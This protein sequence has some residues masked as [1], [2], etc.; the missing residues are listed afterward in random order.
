MINDLYNRIITNLSSRGHI[1][2]VLDTSMYIPPR[3]RFLMSDLNFMK[4]LTLGTSSESN[5]RYIW[6]YSDGPALAESVCVSIQKVCARGH[7]H[8][9]SDPVQA[10]VSTWNIG[11]YLGH[12]S[13]QMP[14]ICK[15]EI[16]QRLGNR[17]D[18]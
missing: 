7:L 3:T 16:V 4:P 14:E 12:E 10:T 2:T 15:G 1:L 18:L 5:N 9:L 17:M 13:S 8:A 11:C 6:S